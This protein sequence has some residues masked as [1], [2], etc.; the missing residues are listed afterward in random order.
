MAEI[1]NLSVIVKFNSKTGEVK[2]DGDVYVRDEIRMPQGLGLVVLR[3]E[4]EDREDPGYFPI[5]PIQWMDE[6]GRPVPQ[7]AAFT[8]RRISDVNTTIQVVNTAL[9][10]ESHPFFVLVQ[11][12]HR[13]FGEDPTIVNQP[14]TGSGGGGSG[15]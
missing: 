15:L 1:A 6:K 4:N 8:V 11:H 9:E 10:T 14:P 3:L 7:P 2:F 12:G 5:N 13:F